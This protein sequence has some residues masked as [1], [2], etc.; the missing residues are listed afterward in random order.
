[1]RDIEV[2]PTLEEIRKQCTVNNCWLWNGHKNELGY[3]RLFRKELGVKRS[4]YVHRISFAR[5]NGYTC[6]TPGI[7]I[8]HLCHTPSCVNPAHLA[9]G[10]QQDNMRDAVKSRRIAH[11]E[12]RPE[13]TLTEENVREI[14]RLAGRRKGDKSE[15]ARRFKVHPSTISNILSGYSWKHLK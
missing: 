9:A 12:R 8:R 11:G 1:M 13:T 10:T 3:G 2:W 6:I 7:V 14:R 15:L 5:A 4:A